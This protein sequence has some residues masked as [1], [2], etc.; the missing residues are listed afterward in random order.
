MKIL[1]VFADKGAENPTLS[2][3]GDVLRLSIDVTGNQWSD[4]IQADATKLPLQPDVE[5]DL[6]WFHPPCGG[7]SPM[8]D[9]GSG[10]R[11]DWP[12]LIP[13]A[14]EIAQ[15][16]CKHWVIENKPRE[17][18]DAEVVLDGHMFNLGIEYKR[19]FETSFSVEQP[20]QQSQLAETSPFF[21][22]EKPHGWWAGV[23]G[24][25]TEF[26]KAHLAKNTI[27]AAYIDYIMRHYAEAVASDDLPNYN[28]YNKRMDAKRA[29]TENDSLEAYQ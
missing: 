9:T 3:Y 29:K 8:S 26:S 28:D 20:P 2:N 15:D 24:S 19:G 11:Q 14:R 6:G 18:L 12:D 4:A 5:F 22:T 27:P 13:V 25:S 21:Y 23:K 10:S 1:Q 17:S 16:H 7:V